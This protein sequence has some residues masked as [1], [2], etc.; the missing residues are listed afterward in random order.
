VP[1]NPNAGQ[2]GA[3]PFGWLAPSESGFY[4]PSSLQNRVEAAI[5]IWAS[6]VSALSDA[7][8]LQ[9]VEHNRSWSARLIKPSE[10]SRS[11]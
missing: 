8:A 7:R 11:T 6:D 2:S 10:R 3:T 1:F 4:Q 9:S 5:N